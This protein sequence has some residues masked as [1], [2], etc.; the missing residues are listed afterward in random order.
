MVPR[1]GGLYKPCCGGSPYNTI[2]AAGR[3][4][5]NAAFLARFAPDFF[6]EMLFE[7]LKENSVDT[8][9]IRRTDENT[10]LAFVKLENGKEPLYSFYTEGTASVSLERQDIPAELPPEVSCVFF[11]SLGVVL[12]PIGTSIESFAKEQSDRHNGPVISYDPNVRPLVIKDRSVFTER[13]Q[14][15]ACYA[16]I[17]K[18]SIA[19]MEYIYPGLSLEAGIEKLLSVGPVGAARLVVCT[20]GKDGAVAVL[21]TGSGGIV[22]SRSGAFDMPVVDTIG[23]GDT[24]HGAFLAF[25]EMN[26]LMSRHAIAS[27]TERDLNAGLVFA[28]KAAAL[29]CSREGA[30]PPTLAELERLC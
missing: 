28:N 3:L 29:V 4:G 27:L 25:L 24:F 13:A 19:D 11:G 23:A 15:L 9:F 10:M 6:G 8:R 2:I 20:L 12:E 22:R 18:I 1:P 30:E 16:N 17:V 21:K 7:R 14:R 5:V 26:G